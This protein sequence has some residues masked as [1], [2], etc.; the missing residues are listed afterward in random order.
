[1]EIEK[2]EITGSQLVTLLLECVW[3]LLEKIV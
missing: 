3:F 2:K 1:M